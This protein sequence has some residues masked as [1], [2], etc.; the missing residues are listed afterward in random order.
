MTVTLDTT[1]NNGFQYPTGAND[2]DDFATGIQDFANDLDAMWDSGTLVARPASAPT[3]AVYYATDANQYF[4]WN[5]VEWQIMLVAGPW[6]ALT[7]G[8]NVGPYDSHFIPSARLEGD[9]IRFKGTLQTTG[10]ILANATLATIPIAATGGVPVILLEADTSTGTIAIDG[11][12]IL[13]TGNLSSGVLLP[14]NGKTFTL[15]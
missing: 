5:G 4:N 8:T 14:L 11:T 7:L 2:G 1:T 6:V 9:T 15:S 13:A 10:S 3:N 12:Q